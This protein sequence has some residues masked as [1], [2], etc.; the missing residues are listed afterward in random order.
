MFCYYYLVIQLNLCKT[1]THSINN[2]IGKYF[3]C[4]WAEI[5]VCQGDQNSLFTSFYSLDYHLFSYSE[6]MSGLNN[7]KTVSLFL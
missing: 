6:G 1:D 4:L 5:T 3:G 2:K 7:P